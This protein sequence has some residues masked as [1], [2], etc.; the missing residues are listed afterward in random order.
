MSGFPREERLKEKLLVAKL[1]A[2]GSSIV[3]FPVRMLWYMDSNEDHPGIKLLVSVP[4]KKVRKAVSRNLIKRKMRE[5]YRL[6]CSSLRDTILKNN[7]SLILGLVFIGDTGTDLNLL[8]SKIILTLLRLE[9]LN[10]K[11]V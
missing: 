5:S 8:D 4:K 3:E 6:N 10:V 9:Q 2:K 11:T 1:F 7:R